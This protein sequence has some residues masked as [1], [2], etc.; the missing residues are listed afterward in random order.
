ME[1]LLRFVVAPNGTLTPDLA[2]KLPGRGAHLTPSREALAEAI[3]TKAFT[4]AFR[5]GVHIPADFAD[6]LARLMDA[7]LLARLALARRAGELALGQDA[8]FAAAKAG[9][10]ALLIVPKDATDNASA[11][12]A[13]LRRDFPSLAFSSAEALG[14]ALGRPRVSNLAVTQG[15]R[16]EQ[17]LALAHKFRDFLALSPQYPDLIE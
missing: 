15:H 3:K 8:V 9:K 7:S 14:Q 1:D 12:L 6:H 10:L 2:G 16:A 5:R 4:R 13:G 11:R 17:F